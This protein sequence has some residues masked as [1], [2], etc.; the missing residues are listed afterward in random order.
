MFLNLF[1]FFFFWINLFRDIFLPILSNEIT[2]FKDQ[3]SIN[4][5]LINIRIDWIIDVTISSNQK[6]GIGEILLSERYR[7]ETGQTLATIFLLKIYCW[8][9]L[10]K[11]EGNALWKIFQALLTNSKS[12]V[13]DFHSS[14]IN[15]N[16]GHNS[17]PYTVLERIVA[18]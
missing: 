15:H 14:S 12:I 18:E 17:G 8:K 3:I 11:Q 4:Y 6:I 16:R 1:F 2:G 9:G 10:I 13:S 7:R 5:C